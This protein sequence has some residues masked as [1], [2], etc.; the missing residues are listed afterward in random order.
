MSSPITSTNSHLKIK[1]NTRQVQSLSE[2]YLNE[3]PE[4][5]SG[6]S[7]DLRSDHVPILRRILDAQN[8]CTAFKFAFMKTAIKFASAVL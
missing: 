7:P 1:L 2:V 8:A 6:H 3:H 5:S 4:R